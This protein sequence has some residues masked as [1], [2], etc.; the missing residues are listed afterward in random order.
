[1]QS[2]K[3]HGTFLNEAF[4]LERT[5]WNLIGLRQVFRY[6]RWPYIFVGLNSVIPLFGM[7]LG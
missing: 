3:K 2:G 7:E 6:V 1:M 5:P 4:A